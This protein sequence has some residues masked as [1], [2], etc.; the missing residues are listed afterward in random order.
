MCA[1]R[2]R[3]HAAD[4]PLSGLKPEAVLGVVPVEDEPDQVRG[5]GG[6]EGVGVG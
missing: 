1:F 2:V 4:F 6:I 5:G 3:A